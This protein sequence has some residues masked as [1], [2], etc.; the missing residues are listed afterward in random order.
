MYIHSLLYCITPISKLSSYNILS[1]EP[2]CLLRWI[3]EQEDTTWL[4]QL[5]LFPQH[6]Q[7]EDICIDDG[8]LSEQA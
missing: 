3:L 5:M 4:W 1:K 6:E 7:Q 8:V 2:Q